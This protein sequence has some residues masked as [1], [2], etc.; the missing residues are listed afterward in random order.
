MSEYSFLFYDVLTNTPLIELPLYGTYFER[1]ICKAANCTFSVHFNMSDVRNQ[2]ILDFTIPGRT[3]MYV[4]RDGQII[5]CY[6][7][8]S[9]TWQEQA[10]QFNFTGQT[11]ESMLYKKL[12][13]NDISYTNADQR[14]IIIDLFNKM[15]AEPFYNLGIVVPSA[16]GST[17]IP[18]TQTFYGYEGWS[19]GTAIDQIAQ[20][21]GGPD[22]VI[23]SSWNAAGTAPVDTLRVDDQLGRSIAVTGTAFDYPGSIKNFWYPENSSRAAVTTLGFGQGEGASMIRSSYTNP[24]FTSSGWPSLEQDYDNS[25]INDQATLDSLTQANAVLQKP[26]V[27]S[28]TIEL[29]ESAISFDQWQ[30]GDY[31]GANIQSDRF[32]GGINITG[33]IIGWTL[34][35]P[36]DST[37]EQMSLILEQKAVDS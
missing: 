19:Y 3:K 25:D 12:I 1:Q 23:E 27:I 33:R 31:A 9:R 18:R 15:Q 29:A 7:I 14:N 37:S 8:W 36:D 4:Q 2:D 32:P 13:K 17:S 16:F 20:L 30:M 24:G 26:L 6:V 22:W 11:L 21:Q 35:P 34:N 10:L 5:A 28:P